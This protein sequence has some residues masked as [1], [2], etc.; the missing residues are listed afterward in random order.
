[1]NLIASSTV[2][3][4]SAMSSGIVST[5]SSSNAMISSTVSSESKPKSFTK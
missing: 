4:F 1:M 5:N 2:K 3:I